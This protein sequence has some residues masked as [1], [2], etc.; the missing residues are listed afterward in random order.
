MSYFRYGETYRNLWLC[1]TVFFSWIF[2]VRYLTFSAEKKG[3]EFL[4]KWRTFRVQCRCQRTWPEFRAHSV[5]ITAHSNI[6][7]SLYLSNVS[8]HPSVRSSN[9]L[10]R[11]CEAYKSASCFFPSPFTFQRSKKNPHLVSRHFLFLLQMKKK[12]SE[13]DVCNEAAAEK[14]SFSTAQSSFKVWRVTTFQENVR[15]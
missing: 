2:K 1:A 13:N 5:G 10:L 9:R 8:I 4:L 11:T 3:W 15:R 12:S 6:P 14:A 7:T